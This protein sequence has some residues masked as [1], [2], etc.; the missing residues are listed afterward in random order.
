MTT[1]LWARI[2]SELEAGLQNAGDFGA[3]T[4]RLQKRD[5]RLDRLTATT[6]HSALLGGNHD[7]K[8]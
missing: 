5:G 6:E 8:R 3:V 2:K 1:E 7:T 4:L